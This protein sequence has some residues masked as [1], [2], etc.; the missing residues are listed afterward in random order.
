MHQGGKRFTG[1]ITPVINATHKNGSIN[2]DIIPKYADHLVKNDVSGVFVCGTAG[3]GLSLTVKE[4]K[5]ILAKWVDSSKGRFRVIAHVGTN[6]LA[7]A[8]ELAR[9]AEEVKADAFAIVAPHYI[10]PDTVDALVAFCARAAAAAPQLPFFYYHFPDIT[11]I[12]NISAFSFLKAAAPVIPNLQGIKFTDNNFHDFG[13]CVEYQNGKYDIL[14]G[15][16]NVLLAGLA[17]GCQ[18]S[19]GITFSLVGNH[20]TKIFRAWQAGDIA[21]ARKEHHRANEFYSVLG[22]YGLIRAHKAA[23]KLKGLDM[24]PC[25]LP[26]VDL[27]PEE[28]Q[29]LLNDLKQTE[30]YKEYFV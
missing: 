4:R 3:E 19:V 2:L 1:L 10:K 11:S 8:E 15:F 23:L 7:D 6:T 26:L 18:G 9:H 27:K 14:N 22:R 12:R 13:S 30:L 28:E 21:T 17:F 16:E 5:E 29:A 20:Y 25:L 24:G